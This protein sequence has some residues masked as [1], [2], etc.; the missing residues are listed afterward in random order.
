M[1]ESESDCTCVCSCLLGYIYILTLYICVYDCIF[2]C[3][4]TRLFGYLSGK[5]CRTPSVGREGV[6]H[7]ALCASGQSSRR[8][9]R[10]AGASLLPAVPSQKS[11]CDSARVAGTAKGTGGDCLNVVVAV[12]CCWLPR[13]AKGMGWALAV[14]VAWSGFDGLWFV[15]FVGCNCKMLIGV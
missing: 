9:V 13:M 11:A 15:S 5:G 6:C 14:V 12:A 8:R 7:L 1:S 10:A 2:A 3:L 4:C